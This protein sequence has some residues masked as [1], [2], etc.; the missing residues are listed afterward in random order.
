MTLV[1]EHTAQLQSS[2][3]TETDLRN[4]IVKLLK[5][6]KYKQKIKR[7]PSKPNKKFY[8]TFK[9]DL[10]GNRCDLSISAGREIKQSGNPFDLLESLDECILVDRCEQIWQC[11]QLFQNKSSTKIIDFIL[12]NSGYELFSD[13]LLASA[14]IENG[15]ATKIRFHVKQ[16]PW[17]ISDVMPYDFNWTIKTLENSDNLILSMFGEKIRKYFNDG[18]I[19]LCPNEYFWTGPYPFWDMKNIN[20]KLY[21]KLS[22]ANLLIFKGDLNYRKLLGDF[23]WP[24]DADF[25]TVLKGTLLF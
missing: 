24:F 5:V 19:E 23:N 16:I 7:N 10:W 3:K 14:F 2:L 6:Y 20:N 17:F 15:L 21:E 1:L 18:Q 12:D 13:F 11:I 4:L 22:E 8:F 9:L 25:K